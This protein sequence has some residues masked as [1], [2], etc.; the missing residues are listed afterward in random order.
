MGELLKR[1]KI[2]DFVRRSYNF[3]VRAEESSINGEQYDV[4]TGRP[5]VYNEWTELGCFSEIIEAGAL[6]GADLT[7]VRF[8][9]NH[10]LS[11]IPLARSRR[12][13]MG[14]NTMQ[15]TPD[16]RGLSLDWVKLDINNNADARALYSAVERADVDGMSFCFVIDADAW[17]D[18]D[19][20]HPKR[21]ITKIKKII[22]VSAVTFPAYPGTDIY[23]QNEAALES[24]RQAL[25]SATQSRASE[26]DTAELLALEKAKF[27][28][29]LRR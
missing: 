5:V 26:V 25:E 8:L 12:N 7:D 21:H 3:E 18:I 13:N 10:D 14:K 24:A 17:E 28:L 6:D 2:N 9:V 16:S 22:E 15:L 27:D 11:K 29:L 1:A 20:N 4:L 19:S 23:V